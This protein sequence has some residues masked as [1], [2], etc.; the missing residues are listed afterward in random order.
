LVDIPAPV[1]QIADNN[2]YTNDATA[3]SVLTG[4][5]TAMSSDGYFTGL[6]SISLLS[7]LSADELSLH[8]G[9]TNI[10]HLSYYANALSTNAITGSEF[11]SPLYN[12][13]FKCNAA[14]EGLM[15]ADVLTPAVKKQLLGE[16]KFT[17][18]FYFFYI[19]NLFGDAPVPITTDYK[20]NTLLH[21]IPKIQVYQ[22]IIDDLKEAQNLLSS[23]YLN[24]NLQAY[25][26]TKKRLRPTKWAATALL[27]RVYLYTGDYTNAEDQATM[28]INNSSL[29]NLSALSDAFTMNSSEAIWQLQPVIIGH[30][31]EDA[32]TFI[33]PPTGPNEEHPV[34]LSPQLLDRFEAGDLRKTEWISSVKVAGT[35]YH[36][37]FKYK[38]AMLDD[39]LTEYLMILRLGEQFLIR[40]EARAQQN[41]IPGAQSDLNAI[42]TRA[43]LTNT[44]ATDKASLLKAIQNERQIEL[45]TEWGHRWMD[46]KRTNSIDAVMSIVTPLK[47]NGSVWQSYQ[48]LYPLPLSDIETAPNLVQNPG[49]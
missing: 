29:Y 4:L 22:Q 38:S 13:I 8:S 39:P 23:E 30:N 49:Y 25:T 16:A 21:R 47:N 11:W 18:A 3:I 12:Y 44:T 6:Q 33:I 2:V 37:P 17:R 10:T 40:S 7:G 42:R 27:S 24:E 19:V 14:I 41:N 48:Q 5:Y 28:V 45:F 31:T 15:A 1:D 46:L 32:W 34:F 9:V 26:D 43:N 20:A 36:Y 35:T